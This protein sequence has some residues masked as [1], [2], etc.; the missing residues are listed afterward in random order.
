ML[1]EERVTEV[2]QIQEIE[3]VTQVLRPHTEMKDKPVPDYETQAVERLVE[4]PHVI[5]SERAVEVPQV[6]IAEVVRQDLQP[7]IKEV[8]REIPRYQVKYT[9]KVHEVQSQLH[10][11]SRNVD[12]G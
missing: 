2:P 10:Q 1:K 11:E 3:A 6:Q 12:V 7:I 5:I 4:V 8:V 9:E